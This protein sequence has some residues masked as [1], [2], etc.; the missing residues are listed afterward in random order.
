MN[1]FSLNNIPAVLLVSILNTLLTL[2]FHF[3]TV[4]SLVNGL[5][6][7]LPEALGGDFLDGVHCAVA[8]ARPLLLLKQAES[9]YCAYL[10][11]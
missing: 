2:S 3:F 11:L 4:E 8:Q 7:E 9:V 10:I 1:M 5:W 6:R